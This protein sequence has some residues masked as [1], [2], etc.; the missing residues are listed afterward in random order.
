MSSARACCCNDASTTSRPDPR[1]ATWRWFTQPSHTRHFLVVLLVVRLVL[2]VVLLVADPPSP[3]ILVAETQ[4]VRRDRRACGKRT[5]GK[6][7]PSGA[8]IARPLNTHPGKIAC[9]LAGL[10]KHMPKQIHTHTH[11][12]ARTFNTHHNRTDSLEPMKLHIVSAVDQ[13]H[14]HDNMNVRTTAEQR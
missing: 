3:A 9:P 10:A 7:I 1:R 11:T 12:Q 8:C 14:G 2:L 5:L 13:H 4:R 6:H